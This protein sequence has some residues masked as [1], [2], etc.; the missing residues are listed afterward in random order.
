MIVRIFRSKFEF[1]HNRILAVEILLIYGPFFTYFIAHS[2]FWW[3]GLFGS[4][5]LERSIAG[6]LPLAGIIGGRGLEWILK[7]IVFNKLIQ[8]FVM[9]IVELES[10]PVSFQ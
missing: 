3:K 8:I 2:I 7:P 9:I 1:A 5:G 6:V 10:R 4:L